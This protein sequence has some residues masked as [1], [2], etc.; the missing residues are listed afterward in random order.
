MF[1][2]V[3]AAL[4]QHSIS[5]KSAAYSLRWTRRRCASAE[6][7]RSRGA[8]PRGATTPLQAQSCTERPARPTVCVVC[9]WGVGG[10]CGVC[11][12]RG[13]ACRA[14]AACCSA[15][16]P[17]HNTHAVAAS[18]LHT[19]SHTIHSLT[20]THLFYVIFLIYW[21]HIRVLVHELG[22]HRSYK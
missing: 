21:C 1:L 9:V 6:P 13:A 22:Q 5:G 8:A 14:P 11:H 4:R 18:R 19:D 7:A 10:V 15:R 12:S 20:S 16:R 2:C 3:V 17:L